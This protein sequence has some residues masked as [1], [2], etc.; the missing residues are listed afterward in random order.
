MKAAAIAAN[1][2]SIACQQVRL[3]SAIAATTRAAMP[4]SMQLMI[5]TSFVFP[6]P[7][8]YALSEDSSAIS[9]IS[10]IRNA[11][12]QSQKSTS[13]EVPGKSTK[14][15][16]PCSWLCATRNSKSGLKVAHKFS[17]HTKL[18]LGCWY[19]KYDHAWEF[20]HGYDRAVL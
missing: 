1:T 5:S 11:A 2:I 14:A 17:G 4:I 8:M 19:L 9:A 10:A 20:R 15:A 16:V 3:S 12:T 13:I 6:E 18:E 7:R